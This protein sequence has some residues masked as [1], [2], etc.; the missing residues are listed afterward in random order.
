MNITSHAIVQIVYWFSEPN[1]LYFPS[2]YGTY[3]STSGIIMPPQ[4]MLSNVS[5]QYW[6]MLE[7][8][9]TEWIKKSSRDD[10]CDDGEG[11]ANMEACIDRFL[12]AKVGCSNKFQTTS[13]AKNTCTTVEEYRQWARLVT[14]IIQMDEAD[15]Y[16]KTGCLRPCKFT[17]YRVAKEGAL[18]EYF[19]ISATDTELVLRFLFQ[20][21]KYEEKEEYFIYTTD[22]F[23]ADVGGYLGLLLGHSIFS[24]V[25]SLSDI[26]SFIK[27]LKK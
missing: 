9:R 26:G 3:G 7:L 1:G 22:S 15:I 12:E 21:G 20:S 8:G 24:I 14:G 19:N 13:K 18:T 2:M 23:I 4:L 17:E 6:Q 16:A 10:E 27:N 25:C 5:Y 11:G